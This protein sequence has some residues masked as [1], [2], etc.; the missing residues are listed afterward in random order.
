MRSRRCAWTAA[1]APTCQITRHTHTHRES[2]GVLWDSAVSSSAVVSC[3]V[4]HKSSLFFIV[5]MLQALC[6]CLSRWWSSTTWPPF[7][8]S[9]CL[10]LIYGFHMCG[11]CC[12]MSLLTD[13][14]LTFAPSSPA[15]FMASLAPLYDVMS[16]CVLVHTGCNPPLLPPVGIKVSPLM[17]I[18][19]AGWQRTLGKWPFNCPP[20]LPANGR[21]KNWL[22]FKGAL[23][24][25]GNGRP[26]SAVFFF[27]SMRLLESPVQCFS[28]GPIRR[29]G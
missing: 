27:S 19:S 11:R 7:V 3:V 5:L 21:C 10:G 13:G 23:C 16:R 24:I 14:T 9:L 12:F 1:A 17:I 18:G 15:S 28:R 6:V 4:L 29:L 25:V 20:P 22:E 2:M 26:A 8:F